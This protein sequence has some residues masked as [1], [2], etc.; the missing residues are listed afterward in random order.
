MGMSGEEHPALQEQLW[1]NIEQRLEE[2]VLI[3]WDGC[4]TINVHTVKRPE[5]QFG[6][7]F[8]N[9]QL[10]KGE[11]LEALREWYEQSCQLKFISEVRRAGAIT[12]LTPLIAQ[13]EEAFEQ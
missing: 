10:S 13:R 11:M 4:H 1:K 5:I 9:D 2:A 8:G 3:E 12:G 6:V 7:S